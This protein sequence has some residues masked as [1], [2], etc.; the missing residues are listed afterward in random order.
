MGYLWCV[1]VC[2]CAGTSICILGF[3]IFTFNWTGS[4]AWVFLAYMLGGVG[5]GSFESNLLSAITPLGHETK[6]W[7]ILGFP[8]GFACVLV[9]GFALTAAGTPDVAIYMIVLAM[10]VCG[11]LVFQYSI[12]NIPIENNSDSFS[13]F[14]DNFRH[15]REWLPP[16][17]WHCLALMINMFAVSLFSGVLLYI[18]NGTQVPLFGVHSTVRVVHAPSPLPSLCFFVVVSDSQLCVLCGFLY[19]LLLSVTPHLSPSCIPLVPQT[20]IP[21]DGFFVIYNLFTLMGDSSSR[22][23]AYRFKPRHPMIFLVLSVMGAVLCLCKVAILA[24]LGQLLPTGQTGCGVLIAGG[25]RSVS[26]WAG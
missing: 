15:W 11:G 20:H 7:A 8:I 5:I 25:K 22:R 26:G 2:S 13:A 21:H 1:R 18:L 16:I 24:P 12:P 6:M 14:V 17:A 3:F 10:L 19:L 9:G 23:V 4:L